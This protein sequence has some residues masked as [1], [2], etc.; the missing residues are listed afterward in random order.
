[1]SATQASAA[2]MTPRERFIDSQRV[3]ASIM[4]THEWLP[5]P[6]LIN[7]YLFSFHGDDAR[8]QMA[9]ASRIF[10]CSWRKE[11]A[12]SE[13]GNFFQLVGQIGG[14]RITLS[15]SREAVCR[16]VVTG[17]HEVTET[18]KDPEALAKV[19]EV[20]VTRVVEDVTWDCGPLLAPQVAQDEPAAVTA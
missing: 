18:V 16:R 5:M 6:Y 15:A 7:G 13:Y 20:T 14:T 4:E 8:E 19:P 2:A 10:P 17:T 12:E 1:M 3:I 9:E 11:A